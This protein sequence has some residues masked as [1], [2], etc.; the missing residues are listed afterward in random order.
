M[1]AEPMSESKLNTLVQK[2]HDFLAHSSEESEETSSPPRLT[3]SQSTGKLKR[4]KKVISFSL[5][6]IYFFKNFFFYYLF[7]D[8]RE[9]GMERKTGRQTDTDLF[10]H[11]FMHSLV[12]FCM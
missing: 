11:L 10:F 9:R 2:L 3:M 1:T 12:A 8:F 5:Y 7:I 6:S 4:K